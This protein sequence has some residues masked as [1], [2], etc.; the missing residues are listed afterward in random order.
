M[1]GAVGQHSTSQT[2]GG[3]SSRFFQPSELLGLEKLRF[4]TRRRVEGSYS[5]RHI[6]KQRGGSG[7]FVDFR[8]YAPGDDLR[9]LDWKAMGRTGRSYLKLFQDET[10]LQCTMLL[11]CSGSMLQG[12]AGPYNA[13]GSKL[14]WSQYFCTALAHLITLGRDAIG[15]ATAGKIL[16]EY[17]PPAGSQR[18]RA[19]VHRVIEDLRAKG[20][21]DLSG[22]LN[23]LL[24]Q[25]KRR[26]VLMLLSDF[27]VDD[28]TPVVA[29]LRNFRAK[30]WEILALHLVHPD[31]V[32]L[33]TGNAVRF[34][35]WEVGSAVNCQIAEIQEAYRE[36]FAK[37]VEDTRS[38]LLAVGCDY[39]YIAT[40]VHYIEFL[41]SLMV[42]RNAG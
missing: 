22:C 31:E 3:G 13:R 27:L 41:R 1:S 18:Q 2:G 17:L 9:R 15:V 24:M 40:D 26:G 20:P 4:T 21:G 19:L 8:E 36:R 12:S 23:E 6:A 34:V 38:A 5:G 33:P 37:H 16:G 32:R 25:S 42:S 39:H 7:E 11:D 14:E 28:L 29:G 10:D 30:G 35:D